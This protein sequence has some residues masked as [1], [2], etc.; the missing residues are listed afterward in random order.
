MEEYKRTFYIT[1]ADVDIESLKALHT[2]FD[3]YLDNIFEKCEQSF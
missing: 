1:I 2:L 3:M